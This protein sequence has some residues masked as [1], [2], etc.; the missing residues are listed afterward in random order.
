MAYHKPDVPCMDTAYV[1]DTVWCRTDAEIASFACQVPGC[2]EDRCEAVQA[3]EAYRK[4]EGI[5]GGAFLAINDVKLY[6]VAAA[7]SLNL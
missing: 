6:S 1:S 3:Q 4:M 2:E 5:G 7:N